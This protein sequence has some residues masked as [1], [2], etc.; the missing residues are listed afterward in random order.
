MNSYFAEN[1]TNEDIR[2]LPLLAFEGDITI[3]DSLESCE[4]AVDTLYREKILG[5]DTE[6]K[7][8]FK[9]G[10]YNPTAM[11]QLSSM[12]EAYLF[13]LNKIGYPK[14]LFDL[15]EDDSILKLGISIDDDLKELRR[16]RSFKPSRFTDLNSIA[17][18]IGIKHIGVKKLAAICLEHRIS[19]GQQTS[20]WEIEEL[21]PS[22]QKYAATDAWICL[23]IYEELE[24]NGYL[25]HLG[26]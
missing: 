26:F 12:D 20:N 8:T 5:F 4:E 7:P 21:S 17:G 2:D 13:R 25:D 16:L 15:M 14:D 18:E 24:E 23:R 10:E 1:I 3:V 11:V 19:K 9:K 22:Q 6:K